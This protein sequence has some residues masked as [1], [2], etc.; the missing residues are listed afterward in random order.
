MGKVGGLCTVHCTPLEFNSRNRHRHFFCSSYPSLEV[1]GSNR[2]HDISGPQWSRL[3]LVPPIRG[4]SARCR[5]A[6]YSHDHIRT[7]NEGAVT[8]YT[9]LML[10]KHMTS[11]QDLCH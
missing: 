7:I 5:K 4:I 2:V 8:V 11:N 6:Q 3:M 9:G 1:A 10:I